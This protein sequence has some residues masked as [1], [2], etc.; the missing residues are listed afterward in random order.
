LFSEQFFQ[1]F[2]REILLFHPPDFR[3]EFRVEEGKT[4]IL[5]ARGF[6]L[7]RAVGG[8]SGKLTKMA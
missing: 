2:D 1:D 3:K 4:R 8:L 7:A 6:A 5:A